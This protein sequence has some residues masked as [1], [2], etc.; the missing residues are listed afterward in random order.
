MMRKRLFLVSVLT[1][2]ATIS[3]LSPTSAA[4]NPQP[5]Q[6][7]VESE[8]LPQA[9]QQEAKELVRISEKMTAIA[10]KTR[11]NADFVPGMVT[12][13]HG[14]DLEA[15]GI[16]TVGE[17]LTLVPGVDVYFLNQGNWM[18][19]VRGASEVFASG[20]LKILIDGTPFNTAFAN[21]P[22]LNMPIEQVDQL[23]VIRGPGSA[24]HGEFAYSGV[25]NVITR[26]EGNRLFGRLG[27]YETYEG[28]GVFS[29][30]DPEREINLS[31]NLA[32]WKTDGADIE[33]GPDTLHGRGMGMISNAPGPTN[34]KM[35]YGA[36][37][38]A[39]DYKDFFLRAQ[40]TQ[41]EQGGFFGMGYALPPP[42]KRIIHHANQSGVEAGY[43]LSISPTLSA[44]F[45]LGY[46]RQKYEADDSYFY[47]PGFSVP[48]PTGAVLPYP[49]GWIYG[50]NYEEDHLNADLDFTYKMGDQHILL[51]G[52]SYIHKEVD[53]VWLDINMDLLAPIPFPL[54]AMRRFEG[55]QLGFPKGK[56]R[57]IHSFIVQDEFRVSDALTLTGGLRYDFYDDID[58]AFS[59]RLAAVY[60]LTKQHI[61]KAQYARAFRPPTF[62][63]MHSVTNPAR[64]GNPDL[65]SETN[66]TFELGYIFRG[67]S[68]VF[69]STLFHSILDDV[70]IIENAAQKNSG[71]NRF[72]GAELELEQEM[73]DSLK[74][75]AD[76]S[77][78]YPEDSDTVPE[79]AQAA[80]WLGNMGLIYQP[81]STLNLALQY[82]YVGDR[83]REL[84]D[85][86]E[87]LD[88]Y[89]TVA[90]TGSLFNLGLKGLTL[91][92]GIK[93]LFDA[94][95]RYPAPL[96]EFTVFGNRYPTYPEDYPRPGRQW[97][98]QIVYEF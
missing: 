24:I 56:D 66:D 72:W 11:L 57:N 49:D 41:T 55:T 33:A 89:H 32:G 3:S 34:E 60:R 38:F 15:R 16:R 28:G 46:Q 93:N 13:F 36:G 17:A 69:K 47:P 91:R 83:N 94:D 39:F 42:E 62:L 80:N 52:Y 12:L 84:L 76:L 44:E 21:D 45:S 29:W 63:E 48:L 25:V 50:V 67:L 20:N 70:I 27:S 92:A 78:V 22:I 5:D 8:Q 77:Y 4:T 14:D 75:N 53:D 58:D 82:R 19:N 18:T 71:R 31:L 68:T 79:G 1:V 81:N 9:D 95:V 40:S 90:V 59:P 23:E 51:L 54:P 6:V 65:K 85:G 74:L 98:A 26:K 37:F 86:R 64:S 30:A 87:N 96:E 10:T 35:N 88:E 97:W 43:H 2:L 61:L 73:G 7:G